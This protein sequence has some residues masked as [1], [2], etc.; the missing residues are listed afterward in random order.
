MFVTHPT[1]AHPLTPARGTLW[2]DRRLSIFLCNPGETV[3]LTQNV[4]FPSFL[5]SAVTHASSKSRQRRRL[6]NAS[7][8][9][10][11]SNA[12]SKKVFKTVAERSKSMTF[13][14][15]DSQLAAKI[16]ARFTLSD[17]SRPIKVFW[18]CPHCGLQNQKAYKARIATASRFLACCS[19]CWELDIFVISGN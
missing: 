10:M 11:N 6:W 16:Q 17:R 7:A 4:L 15:R 2:P 18:L 19:S 3:D 13:G 12:N 14:S 8:V 1:P 9:R 5:E